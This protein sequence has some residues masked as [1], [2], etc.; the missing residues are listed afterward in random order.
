RALYGSE[1]MAMPPYRADL[2]DPLNVGE[3]QAAAEHLLLA[4]TG[5][6]AVGQVLLFRLGHGPAKHCGIVV[7][8]TRFTHA[9]E[10]LGV[11]EADLTEARTKRVAGRF[12]FPDMPQL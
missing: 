1:P 10:R 8:P 11:V 3:L 9:Q 2:R 7:T 4:E 6:V 5:L 12:G